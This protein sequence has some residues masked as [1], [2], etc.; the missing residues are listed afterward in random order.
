LKE[1]KGIIIALKAIKNSYVE[2]LAIIYKR[3]GLRKVTGFFSIIMLVFFYPL[4]R[5]KDDLF[6]KIFRLDPNLCH[7]I[8]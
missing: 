1:L 6:L 4:D 3:C 2:P 7:R 8:L 5:H